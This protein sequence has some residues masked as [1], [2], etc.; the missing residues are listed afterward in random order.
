MPDARKLTKKQKKSQPLS[1]PQQVT[2][3]DFE[4]QLRISIRTV[5][6]HAHTLLELLTPTDRGTSP[7]LN[8]MISDIG[9]IQ[10][11]I[12][13][14]QQLLDVLFKKPAA[15]KSI[16]FNYFSA[17]VRHDLRTPVNA[18]IGYS[19][20]LLEDCEDFSNSMMLK[21]N[22]ENILNAGHH[23]LGLVDALLQFAQPSPV[24][25]KSKAKDPQDK[26]QP[27]LLDSDL[28]TLHHS[29]TEKYKARI[30]PNE[31]GHIL[32]VDDKSSNRDLL[33]RQL[34]RYGYQVSQASGGIMA[35]EILQSQK[36]PIE[37]ILLDLI[38]PDMNGYDVLQRLK[39]DDKL[40]RLPVLIISAL[41]EI[42][43][44]VRCIE[45]GAQ[46]YLQKPFNPIILRAKIN[47]YLEQKH[48]RDREQ[49]F[50]CQ[51][52]QEQ[53][54][55]EQLLLNILPKAIAIRLKRG[56]KTIA[57]SFNEATV[58]FADI[59]GF[60]SL[61]SRISPVELV[62]QLNEI[63]HAFDILAELYHLEKI[64]TIGDA[65]MLVGGV[66]TKLP[67]HTAVVAEMAIDMLDA[68]ERLNSQ[69]NTQYQIR[70]GIH[71]GPVVAGIIGKYK[72]NYDLW[73]DTVNIASRMESQG[74]PDAIQLSAITYQSIKQQFHCESRGFIDIKG[75][76]K[77]HTYWLK[78]ARIAS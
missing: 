29:H 57:D 23:I 28:L 33:S 77:M 40:A 54:K 3:Q 49:A 18:V 76:G 7:G 56:E 74:K 45:M 59:V 64:K 2:V 10:S 72:F 20:M 38:M 73:G 58:L 21:G 35:L 11:A 19:E 31:M 26:E 13:Q 4:T 15:G 70:I 53:K 30:N 24:S 37:L 8:T 6:I 12:E 55:S 9:K 50:I 44:V 67:N 14:M 42:D 22:V 68:I 47:A 1:A 51:L 71:T 5:L 65:Y 63:F 43:S 61:S 17:T 16:D 27:S 34:G 48:L 60:T 78:K 32:I 46:D 52:K 69:N 75:K 25:K 39:E 62:K 36:Y 66:P 41:D